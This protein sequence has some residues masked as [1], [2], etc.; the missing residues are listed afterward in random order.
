MTFNSHVDYRYFDPLP[1]FFFI[2]D[3]HG[4]ICRIILPPNAPFRQ[5][6]SLPCSSKDEAKRAACLKACMELHKMG[7]LT[8]YLLPGLDDENNKE[9]AAH[10]SNSGNNHLNSANDDGKVFF[11]GN[12]FY[13]CD[14]ILTLTSCDPYI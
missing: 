11:F 8:N 6:D 3:L 7:A 13:I 4:T 1:K 2:D 10:C 5:V 9:L 14:A 12:H